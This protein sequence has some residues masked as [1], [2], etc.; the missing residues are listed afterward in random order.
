M[1]VT[2]LRQELNN[3]LDAAERYNQIF[4]KYSE[5]LDN[6]ILASIKNYQIIRNLE[7]VE[8]KQPI[9]V[10]LPNISRPQHWEIWGIDLST[11]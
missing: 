7:N 10:E 1:N 3:L 2:Q 4:G 6:L 9:S 11:Q 8:T 5:D